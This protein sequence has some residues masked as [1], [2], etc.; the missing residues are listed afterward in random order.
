MGAEPM[1]VRFEDSLSFFVALED[2]AEATETARRKRHAGVRVWPAHPERC[3]TKAGR[4]NRL[5]FVGIRVRVDRERH[6]LFVVGAGDAEQS[7]IIEVNWYPYN[8]I[9]TRV[10]RPLIAGLTAILTSRRSDP[11]AI[12]LDVGCRLTW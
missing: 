9:G 1:I 8:P 11:G 12:A 3:S 5:A 6:D 10:W 4:S 7:P 2:E